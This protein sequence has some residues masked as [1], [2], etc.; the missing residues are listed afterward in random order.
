MVEVLVVIA[1]LAVLSVITFQTFYRMNS[2]KAIETDTLRVLLELQKARS[3]TL[4]S[5]NS[6]QYGVHFA[7]TS[8]TIFKGTTFDAASSTNLTMTLSKAVNIATTSLAGGGAD[9]IFKRL[10]GETS[11][12]GTTTLSLTASSSVTKT[13][14]IYETGVAEIQ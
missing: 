2:N 11:H 5:K 12:Y 10:T 14:M 7:T 1:I 9:V 6:S 3:L 4:S 13:I 8:V